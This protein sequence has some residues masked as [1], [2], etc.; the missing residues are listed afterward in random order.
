MTSEPN[1]HALL[2]QACT[3]NGSVDCECSAC[4]VIRAVLVEVLGDGWR[5]A[6]LEQVERRGR[7]A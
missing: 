3:G 2:S 1:K 5:M 7:K 6:V 4:L